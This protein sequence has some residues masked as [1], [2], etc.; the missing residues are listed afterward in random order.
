MALIFLRSPQ[1][2]DTPTALALGSFDGVHAGHR[3]VMAAVVEAARQRP[4]LLP[5]VL[6]FWPHP[7]E[8]LAG[9]RRLRLDLPEEKLSCLEEL[10]IKQLVLVPFNRALAALTPEQFVQQVLLD[11]LKAGAI[12]IGE[13][14]RFGVKRSG[15]PEDLVRLAAAAGVTVEVLPMLADHGLRVSS[16]RIRQALAE[17]DL[18]EAVRL[19]QR[20]YRFQGLVVRG[21][22]LGRGLGWPTANLQVDGRKCLPKEGVYAALVQ[23]SDG[24]KLAAVMNLGRQPTIDPQAPSAVEVHLLGVDL[25]LEGETLTVEPRQWLRGQCTFASLAE[26]SAQIAKDAA[27]A[28]EF[29]ISDC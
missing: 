19:L 18:K 1:D 12:A 28:A 14:F 3:R 17:A 4:Q 21:R 6:T 26:L 16:S 24:K 29:L 2:V 25:Q 13:N 15:G 8:V 27:A 9:E 5:T 20:P 22:G 7:R 11:Q 10:G 23:R